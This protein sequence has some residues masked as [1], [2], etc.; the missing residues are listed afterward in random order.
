MKHIAPILLSTLWAAGCAGPD[1]LSPDLGRLYDRTAQ[2]IGDDRNP[3]IVVPGILGSRLIEP[4]SGQVVWGAFTYGAADVDFPDG[5]RLVSLPMGEGPLVSLRDEVQPDGV[6]QS[7]EANVGPFRVTALEPYKA[8]IRSLIAG[9][10]LDRDLA[11]TAWTVPR[12][13]LQSEGPV[14][15]AGL[16]FTCFQFGFDWRRD[17]SENAQRL[18]TLIR[19]AAEIAGRARGL[20]GPSRVDVVAHSMG[21]L[22]LHYYLRYGAQPLPEDGSLPPV[23]WAGAELVERAIFVGTPNGG[24]VSALR[25]LVEGVSYSPTTPT[26]RPVV[27]GTMPSI[28]QLLPRSRHRR[29]VDAA[30]GEPIGDLFDVATWERYGWGLADPAQDRY[31]RWL[32]PGTADAAGRRD[33]AFDHLAKCLARARQFQAALDVPA[34]PP[35]DL[36]M[37]LFA[38]DSEDTAGVL[39]VDPTHGHLRIGALEPGDGTVTRA[40]ALMDERTDHDWSPGLV[41]PI[42][43]SQVVFLPRDHITLTG[44]AVFTD[45]LLFILLES[46]RPS[47]R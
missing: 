39:E 5:A 37:V 18:D 10:Y 30:T 27:L 25:Q 2:R 1:A 35:K 12:S 20:D 13:V 22:V 19:E 45:N 4:S 34:E 17:V 6:L 24:S 38:G 29:V 21:G 36:T 3:V 9:R 44:D 23:T 42:R 11:R 41:S 40:S 28:Y 47:A 33:I 8:I 43:W 16:H 32:L 7:L 26:Y 46:A 31:L 14:D 15:Y